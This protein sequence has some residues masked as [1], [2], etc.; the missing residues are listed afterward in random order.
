MLEEE[1]KGT[2][3]SL[4]CHLKALETSGPTPPIAMQHGL[5]SLRND[6]QDRDFA[7]RLAFAGQPSTTI[8]PRRQEV[9]TSSGQGTPVPPKPQ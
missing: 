9:A 5:T 6:R 7:R 3:H 4:P 8:A 2:L 1:L